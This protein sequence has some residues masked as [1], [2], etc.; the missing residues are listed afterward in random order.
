MRKKMKFMLLVLMSVS[1]SLMAAEKLKWE[2]LQYA[3]LPMIEDFVEQS[4]IKAK[5]IKRWIKDVFEKNHIKDVEIKKRV[6]DI[7]VN[8]CK[9]RLSSNKN[10][11]FRPRQRCL[12]LDRGRPG[13]VFTFLKDVAL[14]SESNYYPVRQHAKNAFDELYEYRPRSTGANR[15]HSHIG[16]FG[17]IQR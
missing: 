1:S 6:I 2:D 9:E 14:D 13:Y 12:A 5:N 3:T 4:P 15:G 17:S 7:I 10:R 8:E 16:R 11:L